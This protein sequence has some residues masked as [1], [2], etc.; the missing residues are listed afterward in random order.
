[1]II[2]P[3]HSELENLPTFR[4]FRNKKKTFEAYNFKPGDLITLSLTNT[5]DWKLS[6]C[7]MEDNRDLQRFFGKSGGTEHIW[8]TRIQSTRSFGEWKFQIKGPL[9]NSDKEFSLTI[10]FNIE[11]EMPR[12]R[13]PRKL[14]GPEFPPSP[15]PI[16]VVIEEPE[17]ARVEKSV[18]KSKNEIP[19]IEIKGIGRAF[20][21]RLNNEHIFYIDQILSRNPEEIVQITN[22]SLAKVETW[23][24]LIPKIM[25]DVGHP[26]MRKFA[27]HDNFLPLVDANAPTSEIRGIGKVA[28]I[29]LAELG[30]KD[31][32]SISRADPEKLSKDIR[33]PISKAVEWIEDAELKLK[34]K[35]VAKTVKALQKDEIISSTHKKND[36]VSDIPGIGT[37]TYEK[38]EAVNCA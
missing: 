30:Y 12:Y 26:L 3:N 20:E 35:V 19:V 4:L 37:K 27:S 38:L 2:T 21:K 36:P 15:L 11:L 5:G 6:Q 23:F 24:K 32:E 31:V 13:I 17:I 14:P 16:D 10:P 8:E 22:G 25:Q 1:M 7:I 18:P 9:Q 34:G 29:K 28:E 33:R